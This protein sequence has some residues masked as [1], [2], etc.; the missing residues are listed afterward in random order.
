VHA[1]KSQAQAYERR[2]RM[3]EHGGRRLAPDPRM[4]DRDQTPH[5]DR[6]NCE[7][8]GGER[9]DPMARGRDNRD[10][11]GHRRGAQREIVGRAL[12]ALGRHRGGAV[13][14]RQRDRAS[15]H[16]GIEGKRACR[17]PLDRL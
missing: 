15:E 13:T 3:R 2:L 8:A 11:H 9:A 14:R 6:E 10:D 1:E 4:D 7:H 17:R 12:D 5:H 16:D